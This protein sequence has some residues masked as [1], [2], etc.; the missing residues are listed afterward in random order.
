MLTE[1][2]PDAFIVRVLGPDGRPAGAGV[3]VGGRR[4]VTCAHVV[5]VAL[6]MDPRSQDRPDG[7]VTIDF[8]L[9]ALG[10][11]RV[12]RIVAWVPPPREGA[13]GDDVAGL[14]LT[15]APPAG[16]APARLSMETPRVGRMLRVFGFPSSR[17]NGM[18]GATTVQGRVGNGRLQLESQLDAAI[19]IQPGFSG[20]PVIDGD[21]GVVVGLISEAPPAAATARD[22][23]AIS[24]DRMR[25]AW[26]EELASRSVSRKDQSR[27]ELT[28]LH[29]PGPRLGR[30]QGDEVLFGRLL[31]DL[32][33]LAEA[34]QPPL[35]DL[36]IVTGDL[37]L[38]GQR[39][40]FTRVTR[41]L[42][43]L[44]EA[45]EIPRRHVAIVPGSFDVSRRAC[46]AYFLEQE[47]NDAEPVPPFWPKWR[48]FAAAFGD[49]Y[50]D[51]PGVTFTPDEPWT[52]FE[53]PDLNVVVAGL[54][55]TMAESH[56]DG[57]HYGW[58]GE[59]QL[60]WFADRLDAYRLLGYLR[61]AAVHHNVARCAVP[62]EENLRDAG[63]LDRVLG[64]SGLTHLLLHGHAHGSG[65]HYLPSGLAVLAADSAA[66]ASPDGR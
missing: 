39:G 18:W 21:L 34:G 63:N 47:D 2:M 26:G 29:V 40:E 35:P 37:A 17:P 6:G 66:Q 42:A 60:Q 7:A 59:R 32:A 44:A 33:Q 65:L 58:A 43:A 41:F 53:M 25:L 49:F 28:I 16:A 4:I 51:V 13:A 15:A 9:L 24:T 52:L 23:Y 56:R 14:E 5:N 55:S 3:L 54:N 1:T 46:E 19:R 11:Q 50:A 57:E 48:H 31:R 64:W 8:P 61:L 30:G 38:S 62:A 22:S 27:A 36:L 45:A 10:R 12:A 20:G